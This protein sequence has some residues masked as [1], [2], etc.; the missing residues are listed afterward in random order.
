VLFIAHPNPQN[1]DPIII[2]KSLSSIA[3]PLLSA[4]QCTELSLLITAK[5]KVVEYKVFGFFLSHSKPKEY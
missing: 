3:Q 2:T 1:S 4:S 5:S